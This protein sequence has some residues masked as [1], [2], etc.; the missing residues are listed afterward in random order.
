MKILK[1]TLWVSLPIVMIVTMAIAGVV[2]GIEWVFASL[3]AAV[4]IGIAG[5]GIYMLA[6]ALQHSK[7]LLKGRYSKFG[8][9]SALYLDCSDSPDV[10]DGKLDKARPI[11]KEDKKLIMAHIDKLFEISWEQGTEEPAE[12]VS[13]S[14]QDKRLIMMHVDRLFKTGE[15]QS[16]ELL[17]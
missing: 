7:I 15:E 1:R 11:N 17:S 13:I 10:T 3:G 2:G 12:D 4:L 14:E 5:T 8:N 16:R 9:K 6:K